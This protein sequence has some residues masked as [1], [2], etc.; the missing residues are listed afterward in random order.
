MIRTRRDVFAW[1]RAGAVLAVADG[2]L[3]ELAPELGRILAD[4]AL[5][6]G[7]PDLP[8]PSP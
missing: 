2:N 4:A 7:E 3:F 8:A 5:T 1:W 6:R